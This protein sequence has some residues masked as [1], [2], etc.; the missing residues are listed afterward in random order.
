MHEASDGWQHRM[1]TA[2]TGPSSM[3]AGR[4]TTS[5]TCWPTRSHARIGRRTRGS[6]PTATWNRSNGST[7]NLGAGTR[8]TANGLGPDSGPR[9]RAHSSRWAVACASTCATRDGRS[10]VNCSA[11][12][13]SRSSFS[14][15]CR[16]SDASSPSRG[17]DTRAS[18]KM[19][20]TSAPP[21]S[22]GTRPRPPCVAYGGMISWELRAE[23]LSQ[24]QA[25]RSTLLTR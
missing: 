2:E 5:R 3:S 4:L 16:I 19:A 24:E 22:T 18:L 7:L 1:L 13:R 9:P 25:A 12:A 11:T 23:L 10:S 14:A 15:S 21:L 17:T 20:L 8:T 6:I